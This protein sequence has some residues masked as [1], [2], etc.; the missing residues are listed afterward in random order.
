MK[1]NNVIFHPK[2][3]LFWGGQEFDWLEKLDGFMFFTIRFFWNN[4]PK[5]TVLWKSRFR[6][7]F[8]QVG[9]VNPILPVVAE[10]VQRKCD[11]RYYLAKESE[12]W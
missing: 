12:G 1:R 11:V 10:L 2:S 3:D 9:T 4:H 6:V 8:C 5:K 7:P